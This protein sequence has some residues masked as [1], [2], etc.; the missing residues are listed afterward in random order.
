M[1]KRDGQWSSTA[2][3][4]EFGFTRDDELDLHFGRRDP[5][6]AY[7]D[8]MADV[9]TLLQKTLIERQKRRRPYLLIT[10]GWS[11]LRPGK[12]T[13]RSVVRQFMRS[14]EA[15]PLIERSGCVRHPSFFLAK[16]RAI[17]ADI[18]QRN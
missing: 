2:L 17:S 12:T 15:T 16:I 5:W 3:R 1:K 11:T 4:T 13:A 6:T 7:D 10:H 9:K 8:V 18:R 14:K